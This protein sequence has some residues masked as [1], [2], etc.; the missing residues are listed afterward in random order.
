MTGIETLVYEHENILRMLAVV[1]KACL[2][3]LEG[4][5]IDY[6]DFK[7]VIGFIRGYADSHHHGKEEKLLFNRMLEELGGLAEKLV[8]HGMLVEHD[9]GR[10]FVREL[11]EAL[12]K[13]R[14]GD[15]EAKLDVIANA[16]GYANLLK[17][18]IEKED[19]VVYPFSIRELKAGTMKEFD[20]DSEVYERKAEQIRIQEHYLD[21]L[22]RLEEKYLVQ[23]GDAHVRG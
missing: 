22:K 3:I 10:L 20:A 14:N 6:D 11:E 7:S 8:K 2:G 1:R 5:E 4:Q 9:L 23:H 15:Q 18:H 16:I 13:S 17:R 19:K 21:V 12:D